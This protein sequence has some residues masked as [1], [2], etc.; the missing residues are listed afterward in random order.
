KYL[1]ELATV[2]LND[3]QELVLVEVLLRTIESDERI[4]QNEIKF[5]QLV[6][7]KLRTTEEAIITNFP[8]KMHLLI[9]FHNYGLHEEFTED[10]K[11][12]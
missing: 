2:N 11:F 3:K 6:K 10:I 4:E 9:D 8:Q 1:T 12:E 7:S 5:L